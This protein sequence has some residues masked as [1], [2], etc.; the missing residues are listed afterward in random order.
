MVFDI[1]IINNQLNLLIV[2][3]I[4]YQI[5]MRGFAVLFGVMCW[6]LF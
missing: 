5:K 1:N 2:H 3:T 4:I 6:C